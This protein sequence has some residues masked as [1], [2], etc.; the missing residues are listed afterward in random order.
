MFGIYNNKRRVSYRNRDEQNVAAARVIQNLVGDKG[1]ILNIGSGGEEF[2]EGAMPEAY[3]FDVDIT[4]KADLL[5]DLETIK[6]FDCPDGAYEIVVA[7]DLLEHIEN[8]HAM[9]KE[10]FRCEKKY[11]LVS[12]PNPTASLINIFR[13]R[14]RSKS[15]AYQRGIYEKFYGLPLEKPMDRHKWFFSIEDVRALFDHYLKQ[16]KIT[17]V[18]YF[19]AHS[20][21]LTRILIRAFLGRRL[22]YNFFLPNIWILATVKKA[23]IVNLFL[24]RIIQVDTLQNYQLERAME[25]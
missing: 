8:F 13:N 10:M 21:S 9:L 25:R 14:Q 20:W 1:T 22:Y 23:N 4:G 11:V 12:L 5:V 15:T 17:G 19:S 24:A 7:L 16:Q 2:L 18:E 6:T 3:I